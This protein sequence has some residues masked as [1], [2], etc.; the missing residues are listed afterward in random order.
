MHLRYPCLSALVLA[1]LFLNL[2]AM[3]DQATS[4]PLQMGQAG[5]EF[6][7]WNSIKDSKKAEDYQAYLD[8]YPNGN[9]ADLAKLRMKK[10]PPAPAPAPTPAPAAVDPQQADIAYWNS[11][12]ASKNADDYKAYLE[13][14]PN[15]EFVDLAK[16][17]V[18]QLS[19]PAA[20]PAEPASAE[21]KAAQPATT[22][23]AAPE[24]AT[25]QPA[26]EQPATPL[27][28]TP[29]QITTEA[30]A[31]NSAPAQ[32]VTFE[33][34]TATVYAKNGGQVRAAP[35]PKAALVIKLDTNT[36]V[37]ATGLSS[38]GRWWRVE[39]ASGQVGYMHH[40]VVRDRPEPATEPTTPLPT[41][42]QPATPQPAPLPATTQPP[43]P[44][45][46]TTQPTLP[47]TTQP[48]LPTTTQPT[49]PATTQPATPQ[50]TTA[51][52]ATTSPTLSA[53]TQP[54]SFET[55]AGPMT[56]APSSK[57]SSAEQAAP[58]EGVCPSTS[59][60]VPNDRVAACERLVA[61]AGSEDKV[62]AL[63]DL[64]AAL[65][66]ARLYDEAIGKY[67]LAAA[68]APRDATIYY[69]I[70]LLRLDQLRF[71]EARAAFEKA[72]QLDPQNPDILFQRGI[73]YIGV[74]D[75]E[76]AR[77]DVKS[78]LLGEDDAAY[79]EKLGEIEIARG[80]LNSAKVALERG[81]KADASRRSLILAVVNY[82]AGDNDTAAAQVASN[83]D[84]PTAALWNALI[85]KAQGDAAGA[86]QAL[87]AGR[88]VYGD[89]WPGPIFDALSG[90]LNLAQARAAVQ[91]K[92][93]NFE[94]QQ[95]CTL[96]LFAGEWAYLSGDKDAARAALQAALATRAYYTLEFAAAK[97]RLANMGG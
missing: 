57:K 13:K 40:S 92:D 79:Y 21:P 95:L 25:T 70:G 34:K 23:P 81:R 52:P 82:Y 64:A 16:L 17:R 68:L 91:A 29:E 83:S 51:L 46:A 38:D 32:G 54:P 15:G 75:F 12:K 6:A 39:V 22:Q 11:I 3:A 74:G 61:K 80:D 33:A 96:N 59:Q 47:T 7:F 66:Q 2:P 20:V 31:P 73:S 93:D 65:A 55:A 56:A 30:A 42:T 10:Y 77:L 24:A 49:L 60:V 44:L 14:Y 18:E 4:V 94:L 87:K 97:A 90:T 8:K 62:A 78:A 86:A 50:P 5:S 1:A 19:A 76:S 45:P 72:A 84:D 85:K 26:A 53:T 58:D 69:D 37:H 88:A 36:E 48:T 9:F 71:P 41:T 35:D 43:T 28:A 89:T 27:P 67:K 63:G